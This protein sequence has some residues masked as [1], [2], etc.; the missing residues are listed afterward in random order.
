ML[1]TVL[2]KHMQD[3]D[4]MLP[5]RV[6]AFNGD[7]DAPRVQVQIMYLMTTT[8]G[9]KVPMSQVASIP[10]MSMSGGGFV[11]SFPVAVG[12]MGWIKAN[13]QDISLFLQ[14]YEASAGNTKRSHDFSDAVFIPD[15]M[16]G[17]AI[18]GADVNSVVLQSLDGVVKLALSPTAIRMQSGAS[19]VDVSASTV[20]IVS[21]ALTHNGVNVGA[22]H[23]HVGSP[24][25][26]NGP[27]S[28]T[29]APV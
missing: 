8:T 19:Y 7:R 22:T 15:L 29:G 12:D 13:D 4:D 24:T 28:N 3:V 2:D 17:W 27:Q 21:T 1:R 25:A 5:A 14:S 10:V 20:A 18:N 9:E 11:L 16:R 6:V 26:P 23:S